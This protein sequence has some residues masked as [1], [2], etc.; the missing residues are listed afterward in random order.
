MLGTHTRAHIVLKENGGTNLVDEGL[1]LACL[2]LQSTIEH[3]LMCQD[4]RE[5]LI[6]VLNRN[7]RDGLAP[8]VHKL[9]NTRQVLTG[10]TVGL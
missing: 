5:A 1:V 10:S 3:G 2:F 4:R 9:L 8:A 7:L 6:V